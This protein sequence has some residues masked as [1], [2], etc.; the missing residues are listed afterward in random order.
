MEKLIK[1]EDILT[2]IKNI[3]EIISKKHKNDKTPIV[4]VCVLNGGFMFFSDLVKNISYNINI[5]CDFIRVKS[6]IS[7]KKQGDIE[8]TKDLETSVKNKHVYV[9]DDILD[10]GNTIKA[11]FDYLQIKHPKTINVITLIKRIDCKY[12]PEAEQLG[13]FNYG[14][15]IDEEWIIG[16]GMDDDNGFSRNLPDIWEI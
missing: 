12:D 8:I 4:M 13:T 2:K 5:E 11:I 14:F 6:Y 10:S 9:V 16:Y 15:E 3:A 1:E 7:K